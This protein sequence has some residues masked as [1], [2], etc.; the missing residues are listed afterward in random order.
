MKDEQGD[1]T[2]KPLE[3][4]DTNAGGILGG[5]IQ[6][7]QTNTVKDYW[8]HYKLGDATAA[9]HQGITAEG[10][11]EVHQLDVGG[12]GQL[13]P[14]THQETLL[15]TEIIVP[16]LPAIET[17]TNQ[18]TKHKSMSVFDMKWNKHL[19]GRLDCV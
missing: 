18:S 11:P 19:E 5:A 12:G 14:E 3:E 13:Q 7:T 6:Q 17:A 2:P 15:S 4:P 9:V 10:E 1:Q 16:A 8:E